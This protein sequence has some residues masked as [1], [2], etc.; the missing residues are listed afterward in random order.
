[1]KKAKTEKKKFTL[2]Y[3]LGSIVAAVASFLFLPILLDK[4]TSKVYQKMYPVPEED[5]EYEE[6]EYPTE[7]PEE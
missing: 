3:I 6:Y 4:V 1:M 7:E 2:F 5:D